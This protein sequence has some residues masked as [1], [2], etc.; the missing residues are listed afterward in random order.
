MDSG[1]TLASPLS[2][3]RSG[4]PRPRV[5]LAGQGD[6]SALGGLGTGGRPACGTLG[7]GG[8]V[9]GSGLRPPLGAAPGA[10]SPQQ[11][12]AGGPPGRAEGEGLR[13]TA[14]RWQQRTGRRPRGGEGHEERPPRKAPITGSP[15]SSGPPS[16][17]PSRRSAAP[18]PGARAGRGGGWARFHVLRDPWASPGIGQRP[19]GLPLSPVCPRGWR[20]AGL[21]AQHTWLWGAGLRGPA[22]QRSTGPGPPVL[23]VLA[24]C[25]PAPE[26]VGGGP[27]SG[28]KA[29]SARLGH[30]VG[31]R[32][33]T[34]CQ[35]A[36]PPVPEPRADGPGGTGLRL[37]PPLGCSPS[38][39]VR[40]RGSSSR[41]P[42][43]AAGSRT[44]AHGRCLPGGPSPRG[45]AAVS[46]CPHEAGRRRPH[47]LFL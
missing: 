11:E 16:T 25:S 29:P 15:A 9:G 1:R 45:A 34:C 40:A 13:G 33:L 28:L 3:W 37:P 42:V 32:P 30:H 10:G 47:P 35:E 43:L 39:R 44:R 41:R 5:T 31:S 8:H 27:E 2:A 20:A 17:L 23:L 6:P 46:P 18:E 12:A 4:R 21:A 19:P 22:P 26:R 38:P 7:S 36:L 14:G 24:L